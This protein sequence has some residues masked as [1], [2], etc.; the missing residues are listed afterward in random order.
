MENTSV[1]KS[2]YGLLAKSYFYFGIIAFFVMMC[3]NVFSSFQLPAISFLIVFFTVALFCDRNELFALIACCVPFSVAFQ[4]KFGVLICLA[5]YFVKYYKDVKFR[6]PVIIS[7]GVLC[8]WELLHVIIGGESL[9]EYLRDFCELIL[10]AFIALTSLKKVDY[11][12]I[13][14][15]FVIT[16]LCMMTLLFV[17][18]LRQNDFVFSEIFRGNF[19]FGW[20]R[21]ESKGGL[22]ALIFNPNTLGFICNFC[23]VGL[24]QLITSKRSKIIDYVFILPL[25]LFGVMT[26]SRAFLLCL[27]VIVLMFLF[28]GKIPIK[29][30]LI[31]AGIVTFI[32][33]VIGLIVILLMPNVVERFMDRIFKRDD[34]SNGRLDLIIFYTKHIFSSFKNAAF[35][36]GLQN[37]ADKLRTLYPGAYDVCHNGIQEIV[38][39][40][41]FPGLIAFGTFMFYVLRRRLTKKRFSLVSFMPMILILVYIQLGQ[42]ISSG[43]ILIMFAL[44]VISAKYNFYFTEKDNVGDEQTIENENGNSIIFDIIKNPSRIVTFLGRSFVGRLISD[45]LYLKLLYFTK[46][47][48]KLNLKN[49]K[50][51]NEKLQWL[52]LNNRKGI[53]T[54]MVDK[55]EVKEYVTDKI[56]ENYV[57]PTIGVWDNANDIDFEKLPEEFVLKCNH[58]SGGLVI[59]KDKSKLNVKEVREKLNAC[60]KR[61]YYLLAREWPYKNVIPKIIA[62]NLVKDKKSEFLPVYKVMCFNGEPKIIQTIQNDK[63]PNE[64]IDYFNTSWELLD[65]KQNFEN[66]EVPFEKPICLE[67]MLDLS[68]KLAKN[69]PFIRIDWYV[70]NGKL[71]FSEFTFYS[72]AG[73]AKFTPDEWDKKLGSYINLGIE[74]GN[75]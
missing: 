4:Y 12:F 57:I 3:I 43:L 19:R 74:K 18:Q 13:I 39:A 61:N 7:F 29:K 68:R 30:K 22:F 53:Y 47:K 45:R 46:F 71:K 32:V 34:I 27:A 48:R 44:S 24:V 1:N 66:S 9:Y 63:Q 10:C 16:C 49:P 8:V 52:K 5:I 72:D 38:I 65:L 37:L 70:I 31:R 33:A 2:K 58:N 54:V 35:G 69:Q 73:F 14:R 40:W 59:C 60:L 51:F 28:A 55:E 23:L 20:N 26:M 62:E 50:T 56:G 21:E 36:I 15:V 67:E 11:I 6:W 75:D 41:G 17:E 42:F 25:V 64:T